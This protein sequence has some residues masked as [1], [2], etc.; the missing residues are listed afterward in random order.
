MGDIGSPQREYEFEPFPAAE[1]VKEPAAPETAP[2]QPVP[3]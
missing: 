2:A 1:P 3:A